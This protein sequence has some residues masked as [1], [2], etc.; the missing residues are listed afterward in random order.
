MRV[1]GMSLLGQNVFDG[2][3]YAE[4]KESALPLFYGDTLRQFMINF[5][6]SFIKPKYGQDFFARCL[7]NAVL[8]QRVASK[9]TVIFVPD[10]GFQIEPSYFESVLG[11]ANVLIVQL[12]REGCNFA[13]DSRSYVGGSHNLGIEN[14]GTLEDAAQRVYNKM[15]AL[16]WPVVPF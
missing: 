11:E 13:K 14:N 4:L 16:G 6:E 8:Q 10:V 5:S 2:E 3:R 12:A 7:I 15:I 9:N 1:V